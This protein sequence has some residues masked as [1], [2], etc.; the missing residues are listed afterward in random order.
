MAQEETAAHLKHRPTIGR[1]LTGDGA[2][3]QVPL[4]N[5][6]VHV[7]GKGVKLLKIV[8]C[9]DHLSAGGIKDAM[10]ALLAVNVLLV[11]HPNKP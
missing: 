11:L 10:Y 4:I 7:P 1:T 9:T 6:L 5:F 8:D 2:T 3:K